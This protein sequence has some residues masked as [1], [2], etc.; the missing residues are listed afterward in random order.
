MKTYDLLGERL[1]TYRLANGLPVFVMPKP[2]FCKSFAFFATRY[3]SVDTRYRAGGGWKETPAGVAH[4]LEHKMFDLPDGDN[5][6]Q[7]FARTGASPNAF[8]SHGMTAYHFESVSDFEENL[9]LLLRF[10]ST[11]YFTEESVAKERGIIAQEIRMIEDHPHSQLFERLLGALYERHP[12][13]VPIAGTVDSIGQITAGTLYDCHAS[14]YHPAN[15]CLCAAGDLD[16][17]RIAAIAQEELPA[18]RGD[19][20]VSDTGEE[21]GDA[22]YRHDVSVAMEVS[23][24]LFALGFVCPPPDGGVASLRFE[25]LAELAMEAIVGPS[26]PLYAQLYGEELINRGFAH[27]CYRAPG[28]FMMFCMGESRDPDRVRALLFEEAARVSRQGLDGDLFARLKRAALGARLRDLDHPENTCHMQADA[29]FLGCD[30]FA[31]ASLFEGLACDMAAQLL[32]SS[33]VPGRSALSVV[34]PPATP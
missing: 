3:G 19:A 26:S 10:V 28:M 15:M 31:F 4:F 14:F 13:R 18:S 9:R 16:G 33:L 12:V 1:Y 20:A 21:T 8:T 29:Y 17:A 27:G 25:L 34:R 23:R 6:L 7:Q 2:G 32:A 22:A 5:A 11:P 30:Y 24:P